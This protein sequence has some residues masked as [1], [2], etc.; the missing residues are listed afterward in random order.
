MRILP[1]V[2]CKVSGPLLLALQ[3]VL[4]QLQHGLPQHSSRFAPHPDLP[5]AILLKGSGPN[6]IDT[7]A[8]G[9]E[10]D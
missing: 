9:G 4:Q 10:H 7:A 6:L 1:V 3:V 8:A 5:V 2:P